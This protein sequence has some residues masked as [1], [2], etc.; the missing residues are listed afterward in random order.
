MDDLRA[1]AK[2]WHEASQAYAKAFQKYESDTALDYVDFGFVHTVSGDYKS[3]REGVLSYLS[4]GASEFEGMSTA[5]NKAADKYDETEQSNADQGASSTDDVEL[6]DYTPP[7][8]PGG[9]R[10]TNIY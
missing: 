8:P 5:L 6:P 2:T 3:L 4:L 1:E 10:P 7:P 9:G